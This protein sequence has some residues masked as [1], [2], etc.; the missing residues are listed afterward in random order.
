MCLSVAVSKGTFLVGDDGGD[1]NSWHK[2][3]GA[4]SDTL[5]D[6]GLDVVF[7]VPQ[8]RC[9]CRACI[10]ERASASESCRGRV[11]PFRMDG[12]SGFRAGL[13]A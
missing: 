6:K 1:S 10:T 13:E 12:W 11:G 4:K 9:R 8:G 5:S 2:P 7:G 3:S